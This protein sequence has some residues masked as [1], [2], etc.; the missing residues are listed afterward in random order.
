M[1]KS[2]LEGVR[3]IDLTHSWSGPHGTRL[4][5]DYGAEVIRVEY[6]KRICPLRGGKVDDYAYNKLPMWFQV[7]RN[8]YSITLDLNLEKDRDIFK[9]LVGE[10]DVVV[11]NARGGVLGKLGLGYGELVKIKPDLLMVSMAAFGNTGPYASYAG[12]GATIEALSGVQSLTAYEKDGKPER[13]KEMDVTSGVAGACA[14]MTGLIHRQRTGKGQYIDLAQM[15]ASTHALIGE[16]ML[17]FAMN[18]E[19]MI[20]MGARH[21][22]FAPQGVYKCKGDDRWI[23][24]SIRTGDEWQGLCKVIG[25][26]ELSSVSFNT[27]EGRKENQEELDGIIERWSQRYE[28]REAMRM[29]QQAGVPAGAVLDVAELSDDPHLKDRGYFM[30]AEDGEEGLFMGMPFKLSGGEGRIRWRGPDLGR[31]NEEIL[32][33]LLGRAKEDLIPIDEDEIGTAFDPE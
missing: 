1:G 27:I 8:K 31:H 11:E 20:P 22:F 25:D 13:V 21:R 6:V 18:G 10:A 19:N 7:N 32:T 23:A 3:I 15:E 28:H 2:A 17:E 4:L 12:Y 33:G 9:S 5:A 29:L 30:S 24:I 14:V 26:A 16:H